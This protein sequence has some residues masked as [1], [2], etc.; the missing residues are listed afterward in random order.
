VINVVDLS[1]EQ[2]PNEAMHNPAKARWRGLPT[3]RDP[4]AITTIV[5]HQTACMYGVGRAA[6]TGGIDSNALIRPK[7]FFG[8]AR[9]I[10]NGGS[11]TMRA[12][13]T[14]VLAA[15]TPKNQTTMLRAAMNYAGVEPGSVSI[16]PLAEKKSAA[17]AA[18]PSGLV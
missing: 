10:E 4:K 17:V 5:L 12:K 2:R 11:L 8:S 18:E 15:E 9:A 14:V 16:T 13:V 7:K 6:L 1:Y 3:V